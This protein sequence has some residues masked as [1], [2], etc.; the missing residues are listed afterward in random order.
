MHRLT[1]AQW[2][3]ARVAAYQILRKPKSTINDFCEVGGWSKSHVHRVLK[4]LTHIGF[5]SHES[6]KHSDWRLGDN[7]ER[8]LEGW[9]EHELLRMWRLCESLADEKGRSQELD[10]PREEVY[11]HGMP[12]LLVDGG[13][14]LEFDRP[15]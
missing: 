6:W 15:E 2:K 4:K 3:V 10:V 1:V 12:V 7:A 14:S 11:G 13:N 5:L 9:G 8:Y